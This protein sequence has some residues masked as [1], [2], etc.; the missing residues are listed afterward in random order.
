VNR[1][2]AVTAC[3]QVATQNAQRHRGITGLISNLLHT[4]HSQFS[5]TLENASEN[6][7]AVTDPERL[8]VFYAN[9]RMLVFCECLYVRL[10]R[11]CSAAILSRTHR[12]VL[13]M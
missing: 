5:R 2:Q 1:L 3:L 9:S 4:L 6:A 11:T 8:R 12:C 7:Y 13:T 10:L